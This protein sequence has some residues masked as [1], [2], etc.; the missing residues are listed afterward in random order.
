MDSPAKAPSKRVGLYARTSTHDQNP[1]IQIDEL[2]RISLQRGWRV[3]GEYVDAGHSGAKDRRPELDRLMEDVHRGRVDTVLVW[4]FDRF[5]RSVRH[6]VTALEEF[7]CRSVD[8]VSVTDAIDTSTPVGR[9]TFNVIGAVAELER[10]LIRERTRA[11]IAAA[12]RRGVQVGRP[13]AK[14][15]LVRARTLVASGKSLRQAARILGFGSSTLHRALQIGPNTPV[16]ET[17]A[18]SEPRVI[19]NLGENAMTM[20]VKACPQDGRNRDGIP[21]VE[22]SLG[23]P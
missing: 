21:D 14:M 6:L 8:F 22:S 20:T 2:R 17:S 11:G 19:A 7:R 1:G 3:V 5:A 16:P 13:R 18:E 4:K 9:F 10:E 12:R 23:A 15:D